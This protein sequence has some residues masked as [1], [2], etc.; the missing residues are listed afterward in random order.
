MPIQLELKVTAGTPVYRGHDHYWSVIRDLGAGGGLFTRDEV[1]KRC[2]DP[3]DRC[4]DDFL[5]RLKKAGYLKVVRS[6]FGPTARGGKAR[7]DVY[8]LLKRPA[9]TPIVNRDGSIGTQGLGQAQMWT[10]MR[11]LPHFTKHELAIVA[12]TELV[13]VAVEAAS[14]YARLLEKAGYLQVVRGGRPGTPR[15]WRLKPSMNTGPQ[16]PK[17]LTGKVVWDANR[18]QVMGTMDAVEV[19]A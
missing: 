11:S 16:A 5:G 1:C 12:S 6:E 4:I 9:Q 7:A 3:T 2:N 15:V 19:A 18:Q 14:R 10:A 8:E 13:R 17:I